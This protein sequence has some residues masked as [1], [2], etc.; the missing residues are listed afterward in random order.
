MNG[1]SVAA[2]GAERVQPGPARDPGAPARTSRGASLLEMLPALAVLAILVTCAVAALRPAA[3]RRSVDAAARSLAGHLRGHA[4]RALAEGREVALLFPAPGHEDEPLTDAADG[5]SD[6]VSRA[7]VAAGLD[8]R[9]ATWTL[10]RDFPGVRI[11][12][13]PWPSIADV[14]PSTGR[15]TP[16]DPSV[17][18]GASRSVVFDPEGHATPGTVYVTDRDAALCAVVVSGAAAR[19]RVFCYEPSTDTWRM[20]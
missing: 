8:E 3:G 17:R 4:G 1:R 5:A 7:D 6:G 14:P 11:G 16:S 18:F 13:P 12:R 15:L 20:R 2:A 19:I 10:A 9:L